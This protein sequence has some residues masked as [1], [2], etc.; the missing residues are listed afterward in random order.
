MVKVCRC[1][2]DSCCHCRDDRQHC[3]RRSQRVAKAISMGMGPSFVCT[4][5]HMLLTLELG[6]PILAHPNGFLK[7]TSVL[8]EPIF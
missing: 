4:K 2:D 8:Q 5:L 1:G 3:R 6:S 7:N